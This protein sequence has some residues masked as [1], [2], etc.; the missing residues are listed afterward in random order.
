VALLAP[1]RELE[2]CL[3]SCSARSLCRH[4]TNFKNRSIAGNT[5]QEAHLHKAGLQTAGVTCTGLDQMYGT[6]IWCNMHTLQPC[7]RAH[8]CM[9]LL[10]WLQAW[11]RDIQI[12]FRTP[13]ILLLVTGP[14]WV[15]F[16]TVQLQ[17][18]QLVAPR[19]QA[20]SERNL[21]AAAQSRA[22]AK[23]FSVSL[24]LLLCVVQMPGK[25]ACYISRPIA[26]RIATYAA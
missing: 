2:V 15:S 4:G 6:V 20:C 25:Q 12:R 23:G 11:R 21:S 7:I 3:R 26:A 16:Q 24:V 17:S 14:Y 22:A 1:L 19:P 13:F 9:D 10:T 5:D 8:A 18:P